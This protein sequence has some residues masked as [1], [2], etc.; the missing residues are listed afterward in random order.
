MIELKFQDAKI[1][2]GCWLSIKLDRE[3]LGSARRFLHKKKECQYMAEIREYRKKRSLD[4]NAY[5][6]ALIGNLSAALQIPPIEIY[7][8]AIREIGDNFTIVPIRE[9]AADDW[10]R[11]WSAK[12]MGWFCE[13]LGKSKLSGYVNLA[14]FHGSSTYNTRQMSHLID[15]IIQECRQVGI[16]TKTPDEIDRMVKEWEG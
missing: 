2:N 3:C 7:R 10:K 13:D 9:D 11:I 5:C 16:E 8:E 1:E 6:W 12:G 15:S 4:A 14:C